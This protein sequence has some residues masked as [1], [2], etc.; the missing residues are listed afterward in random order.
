MTALGWNGARMF[1]HF[2]AAAAV[3]FLSTCRSPTDA[4]ASDPGIVLFEGS[5]QG[6]QLVVASPDGAVH[7]PILD[8]FGA[9]AVQPRWSPDRGRIL[10]NR[11]PYPYWQGV[12]SP[13]LFV[14]NADGSG[15]HEIAPGKSIGTA[16]W[17]PDGNELVAYSGDSL[18]MVRLSDE[19]I[20][21]L[22]VKNAYP[23]DPFR[24]ISWS[25]DGNHILYNGFVQGQSELEVFDLATGTSR[26]LV[27]SGSN[28]RWSPDG[29]RIAY[30]SG[31]GRGWPSNVV[32]MNS[33]GSNPKTL[34]SDPDNFPDLTWSPDG[35]RLV[36]VVGCCPSYLASMPATGGKLSKLLDDSQPT[37]P[38]WRRTR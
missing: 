2:V 27:S 34:T 30:G 31:A 25:P 8:M 12:P 15:L 3:V 4:S 33:D 32:V 20:T 17:S 26:S 22:P 16:D 10:F 37:F 6:G 21:P 29:S 36:F 11:V 23:Y 1:R 9:G 5:I 19:A 18:V 24:S 38:D 35:K 7:Q 14:I 13:G 28:G